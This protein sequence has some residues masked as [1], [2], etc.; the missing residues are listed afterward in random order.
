MK[1][2]DKRVD[3][4]ILCPFCTKTYRQ[5]DRLKQHLEK[6]HPNEANAQG[7]AN[8]LPTPSRARAGKSEGKGKGKG[9]GKGNG[10]CA[11]KGRWQHS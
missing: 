10:K 11:V 8:D 5:L 1:K 2:V 4:E 6:K 9:K 7:S 3:G